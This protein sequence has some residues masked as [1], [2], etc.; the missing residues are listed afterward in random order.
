[1][2]R[3]TTFSFALFKETSILALTLL[4]V[5]FSVHETTISSFF[6]IAVTNTDFGPDSD[7]ANKKL[8]SPKE[9]VKQVVGI[10]IL[11][12]PLY[13]LLGWSRCGENFR[14]HIY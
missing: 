4:L 6:E 8:F 10:G 5:F 3:Q 9:V 11:S 14:S 12:V 1:M 2:S 13:L 7:D